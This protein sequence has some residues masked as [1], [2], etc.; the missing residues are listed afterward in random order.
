MRENDR[1][2]NPDGGWGKT[3]VIYNCAS[4]SHDTTALLGTWIAMESLAGTGYR[5][6]ERLTDVMPRRGP[7]HGAG[8]SQSSWPC[9]ARAPPA[10]CGSMWNDGCSNMWALEGLQG[11]ACRCRDRRRDEGHRASGAVSVVRWGLPHLPAR[12]ASEP[13]EACQNGGVM[14]SRL[15]SPDGT[16]DELIV[17]L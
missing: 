13:F 15:R 17:N 10:P 3:R 14:M 6:H 7:A 1:E 2:K 9:Q 12:C 11:G 8:R 16:T 5:S 4:R